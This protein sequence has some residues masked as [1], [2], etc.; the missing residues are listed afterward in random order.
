MAGLPKPPLTDRDYAKINEQLARLAQAQMEIDKANE[1]G[2]PCAE[3]DQECK[4]RKAM[5]DKIKLAYFPDR[6]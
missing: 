5:L 3:M 1:A 2:F 4:A 6:P